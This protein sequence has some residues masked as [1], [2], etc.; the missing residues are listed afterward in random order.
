MNKKLSN[1]AC[2]DYPFRRRLKKFAKQHTKRMLRR[3]LNLGLTNAN[4]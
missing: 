1:S 4:D 3:K 2:N